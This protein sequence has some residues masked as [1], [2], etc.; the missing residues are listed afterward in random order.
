[1]HKIRTVLRYAVTSWHNAKDLQELRKEDRNSRLGNYLSLLYWFY[2]Y[3]FDYNDYVTFRFWKK[4][5]NQKKAYISLR[6]NDKLRFALST[7][8]VYKLFLDKALFNTRFAEYIYRS[9]IDASVCSDAGI[10]DFIF[11]HSEVI[12]KPKNDYG[13]HGI[14][15]LSSATFA[16]MPPPQ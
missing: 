14:I 10:N 16:K 3:G 6:R 2:R 1:M 15:K 8:R 13:G 4:T 9:W 12:A 11:L 7:P 5:Y